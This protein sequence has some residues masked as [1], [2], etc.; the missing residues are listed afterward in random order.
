ML[1]RQSQRLILIAAVLLLTAPHA[2][3]AEDFEADR[4]ASYLGLSYLF[5][6][7]GVDGTP[8]DEGHGFAALAG[9]R[10]LRFAAIELEGTY[11]GSMGLVENPWNV[12]VSFKGI[13]PLGSDDRIQPFIIAGAGVGNDTKFRGVYKLGGGLDY[14]LTNNWVL[15]AGVTWVSGFNGASL[16]YVSLKAGVSY[17]FD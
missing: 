6:S 17:M 3:I 13:Y 1:L 12:M 5:G 8:N 11:L 14:F 7:G 16:E 2:A 4:E 15:G 9:F 10:M